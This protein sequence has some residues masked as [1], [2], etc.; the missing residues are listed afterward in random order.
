MGVE[1]DA[2]ECSR[3]ESP[4][5]PPTTTHS[6]FITA[7]EVTKSVAPSSP[8]DDSSPVAPV[9]LSP[10]PTS[11]PPPRSEVDRDK[12]AEAP[13]KDLTPALSPI[14]SK[15]RRNVVDSDDDDNVDDRGPQK[16]APVARDGPSTGLTDSESDSEEEAGT[17]AA[18]V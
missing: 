7:V 9:Q 16:P 8:D 11:P 10:P 5:P 6:G 3:T 13:T 1:E 2:I 4:S 14:A 17:G 12:G 15:K 18:K